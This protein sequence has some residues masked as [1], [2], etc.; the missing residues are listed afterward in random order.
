MLFIDDPFSFWR[1]A[2]IKSRLLNRSTLASTI[3]GVVPIEPGTNRSNPEE[4]ENYQDKIGTAT[5]VVQV[6]YD[7][8]I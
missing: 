3:V 6:N 4:H 8:K 7:I 5:V 2:L 1:I